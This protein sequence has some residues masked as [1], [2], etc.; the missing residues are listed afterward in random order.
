[1]SKTPVLDARE[2]PMATR[3]QT[4]VARLEGLQPG[5]MLELVAPHEPSKLLSKLLAEFPLRFDF[6]P[7]ERGPVAWRYHVTARLDPV[8]RSVT[9]YLAWDHDRLDAM[10]EHAFEHA[11]HGEWPGALALAQDFKHGL[12]RH[13]EIEEQILFPAFEEATGIRDMGPTV[14][15]RHEHVDIKEAVEGIVRG[16]KDKN[17]DE[18]ERQRANLLGVLIEHNMKEEQILY[19][20]TDQRLDA[21]ALEGL[22]VKLMLN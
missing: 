1:M 15:M 8:P 2:I 18:M 13:I 6:S 4:I 16:A 5:E 12:F 14:V 9:N 17:L 21:T 20:S 11:Q 19:P 3:L 10:L 7:L 22:V